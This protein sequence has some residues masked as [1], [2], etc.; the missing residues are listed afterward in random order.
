MKNH[1]Y[2][3]NQKV[4]LLRGDEGV[5]HV[6]NKWHR[7]AGIIAAVTALLFIGSVLVQVGVIPALTSPDQTIQD[8]VVSEPVFEATE[9]THQI[10][11]KNMDR[12]NAVFFVEDIDKA[13]KRTSMAETDHSECAGKP[14]M[15][16]VSVLLHIT[17]N[18]AGPNK[19]WSDNLN[20]QVDQDNR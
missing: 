11:L 9:N 18:K 20:G 2:Q 5:S 4:N 13:A 19:I 7:K 12:I 1:T 3:T 6:P 15:S 8:Q 14:T 10:S 17:N 16:A